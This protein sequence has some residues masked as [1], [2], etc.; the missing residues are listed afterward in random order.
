MRSNRPFWCA[1]LGSLTLLLL[2]YAGFMASMPDKTSGHLIPVLLLCVLVLLA[3]AVGL[4][5]TLVYAIAKVASGRKH[6][7]PEGL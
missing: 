3:G 6:R 7:K 1:V 4:I 2:G 5:G